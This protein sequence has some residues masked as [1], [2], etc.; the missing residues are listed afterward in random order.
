MSERVNNKKLISNLQDKI[1]A[2]LQPLIGTGPVALVDFPDHSNVGDSAIWLGEISYLR[3]RLAMSPSYC[4]SIRSFSADDLARQAPKG[5][6]LIHG[7]GNF[8]TIWKNHHDFLLMLLDRYHGRPIVQLPQSIFFDSEA[9][10]DPTARAIEKHGAFT[11]LVRDQKSYDF[12][13]RKFQCPVQLCPDMAFFIGASDRLKP[14]VDFLCLMRSD[15]EKVDN[16][17]IP[18]TAEKTIAVDWLDEAGQNLRLTRWLGRLNGVMR[19]QGAVA[20]AFNAVA[21][22]RYQRGVAM[23]SRGKVVVTDRL[24][25]HIMSTLLDIPHVALDNSY[26]KIG[27]FIDAWTH[28]YDGL[29]RAT[30]VDEAFV[31]GRALLAQSAKSLG[32]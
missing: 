16:M 12:A 15:K 10:S 24:H 31:Q 3:K 26:G 13:V 20:G 17:A 1:A 11:L 29:R 4:C 27:G 6:I 5:P 8:G 30:T 19:G 14:D 23:L 7:G 2:A 28:G 21:L 9:A 32:A 18:A 25:A 22:N